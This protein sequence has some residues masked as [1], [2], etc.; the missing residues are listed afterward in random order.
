MFLTGIFHQYTA[1]QLLP[2]DHPLL[3]YAPTLNHFLFNDVQHALPALHSDCRCI[4]IMHV[5]C[6]EV[7]GQA[8][9]DCQ[10]ASTY[11]ATAAYML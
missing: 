10:L 3:Q 8:E 9:H 11:T 1:P 5:P 2:D 6:I 7:P 4:T